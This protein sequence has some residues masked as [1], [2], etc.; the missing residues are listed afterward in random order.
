MSK[1]SDRIADGHPGVVTVFEAGGVARKKCTGCGAEV[2]SLAHHV[3]DVTER[4]TRAR[5]R[6]AG[7]ARADRVFAKVS[8][9]L[10]PTVGEG[11][12]GANV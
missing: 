6:A 7:V 3:A 4:E 8:A 9:T 2:R 12:G 11:R 1:F 10:T 5:V